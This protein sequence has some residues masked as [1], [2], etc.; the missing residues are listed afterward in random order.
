MGGLVFWVSKILYTLRY[1]RNRQDFT[2][3]GRWLVLFSQSQLIQSFWVSHSF[4]S[5]CELLQ[6]SCFRICNWMLG[7]WTLCM[8][9]KAVVM[10]EIVFRMSS[11]LSV[12]FG[13]IDGEFWSSGFC[14]FCFLYFLGIKLGVIFFLVLYMRFCSFFL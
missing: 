7:F 2:R 6:I 9:R 11:F 14:F 10:V 12:L 3:H 4:I 8:N 13:P 1:R 5:S